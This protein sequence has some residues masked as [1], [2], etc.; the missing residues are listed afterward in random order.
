VIVLAALAR[1]GITDMPTAIGLME[2]ASAQTASRDQ[3]G[4]PQVEE[5]LRA[6]S[7]ELRCLV[8]QNQ[9]L[10]D[11]HADLAIDLRNQ[12]RTL[13]SEGRSDEEVKRWLVDRYGD[14]VLYRPPVKPDTWLLWFGPFGLLL[15]GLGIWIVISRQGA[16]KH[17]QAN[18]LTSVTGRADP[19]AH[20]KARQL[21][22]D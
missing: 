13:L 17:R 22:E 9:T 12:V 5:R 10:A 21:L 2:T 16:R 3:T 11:S 8:C 19:Q 18:P 20:A 6:L 14:F 15:V 1:L 4:S 7:Q